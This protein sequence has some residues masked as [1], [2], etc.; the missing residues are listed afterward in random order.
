MIEYTFTPK[1][2][3]NDAVREMM[4]IISMLRSP[5]GCP[6]D[7]TMT[8][9]KSIG[10]LIDEAYEYLDEAKKDSVAGEREEIGDVLWNAFFI[11]D[12][13]NEKGE[14]TA[15]DAI[16]EV[17]YKM[18]SRHEHVF[19]NSVADTPEEVLKL[20]S[21]HKK[22]KETGHSNDLSDYFKRIPS[23]LSPL[24]ESYE[25]QKK[26]KKLG[27]EFQNADSVALKVKE[28]L[29]EVQ[30][31]AASGNKT[32]LE[33][34]IGDLLFSVVNL[35]RFY[36]V[37]PDFALHLSSQK[38]KRRFQAVINKALERGIELTIE[39]TEVLDR[40]WDEVKSSEV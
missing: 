28:E 30:K 13:S 24:E 15:L 19:G 17:C 23:S 18:V 31:A 33:I 37:R 1:D 35:S 14:Y 22:T 32:E 2:N 38:I 6:F 29:D 27:L 12:M 25:V 36:G 40:L 26:I 3:L 8:K 10:S 21:K 11:M 39:N 16:N 9:E 34:E 7:R 20:W 5:E 4:K